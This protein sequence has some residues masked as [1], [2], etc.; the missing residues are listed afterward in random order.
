LL[1]AAFG[2][3]KIHSRAVATKQTDE[4]RSA[5][6]SSPRM[7]APGTPAQ[8]ALPKPAAAVAST[9][10]A[11]SPNAQPALTSQSQT[12]SQQ[13]V[14]PSRIHDGVQAGNIATP[15]AT[16]FA[17]AGAENF[18]GGSSVFSKQAAPRVQ[19]IP[20]KVRLS[21]GIAGGLLVKRIDPVYPEI[22]KMARISGTVVIDATISKTGAIENPRVLSGPEMLRTAAIDAVRNWRYR[23]YRLNGEPV[24][25]ETTVKVVFALGE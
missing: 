8:P 12:M 16:N 20:Q 7:A 25:V 21:A 10:A 3:F 19:F 22:A 15:P 24:D 2:Y 17:A 14:A 5:M 6:T 11:E 4:Q 1:L 18:D 23:P 13:L 9:A